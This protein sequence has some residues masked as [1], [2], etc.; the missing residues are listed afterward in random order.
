M[1]IGRFSARTV[2]VACVS[3][4]VSI[5]TA[6]GSLLGIVEGVGVWGGI[7]VVFNVVTTTGFGSGPGTAIG[8]LLSIGYFIVAATCWFFI[9]IVAVETASMRFQKHALID[10]ALR[11]LAR[12][13]HSR[14]FHVN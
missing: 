12:R 3:V 6:G 4:L 10:E 5:V 2:L 11:P 7:W 9:L 8:Q 1:I 14:L 13:P